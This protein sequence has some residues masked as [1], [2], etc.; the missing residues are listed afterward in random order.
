MTTLFVSTTGGHLA[1][2][3]SLARRVPV[4]GDAIWVTH[5][6]EQSRSMLAGRAVHFVP[7]VGVRRT[8]D[9]CAGWA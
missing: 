3:D 8:P 4:D 9:G 7:Y 6:N 2:L 1:E 5:D